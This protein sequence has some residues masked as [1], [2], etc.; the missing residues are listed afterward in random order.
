M[1]LVLNEAAVRRLGFESPRAA[2]GRVLQMPSPQGPRDAQIIA[3]VPDISLA[4]VEHVVQPMV[5]FTV[6]VLF[7]LINVKLTGERI[8]ET[9]QAI[10]RLWRQTGGTAPLNRYFLDDHI[11]N[12]YLSL[13]R[14]AQVFG[15]SS[16][17]A[18]VLACLG[19]IGLSASTAQRRT[20]EIGIRKALGAETSH[21]VVLLLWQFARPI[22]WANL[23]AWTVAAVVMRRWLLGFAY[24]VE[25][26]FRL[27]VAA[28][29]LALI[30]ALLTVSAHSLR[31][32]RANPVTALR[33]E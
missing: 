12:Q 33:Y 9:L 27:F 16:A 23:I 7:N 25:L 24:H 1:R 18:A 15:I 10:D 17:V 2:V 4:S 32:A 13:L 14:Q 3:V 29:A 8:P 20:R 11:Q 6:P 28:A 5:Y 21:I 30:T 31:L 26:D 19:L 22:L